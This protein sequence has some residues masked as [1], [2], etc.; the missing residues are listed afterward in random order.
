MIKTIKTQ[1]LNNHTKR[2]KPTEIQKPCHQCGFCPYGQ[3][4][5]EF[6]IGPK[7]TEYSCEVFGHDCPVY[8][9]AEF[10]IEDQPRTKESK[11]TDVGKTI[12]DKAN[13]WLDRKKKD[14]F[15]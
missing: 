6:P 15:E 5:E 1:W 11:A 12:A 7:R 13:A 9:H 4:V 10:M 2:F 3:L 8:Y 14:Y